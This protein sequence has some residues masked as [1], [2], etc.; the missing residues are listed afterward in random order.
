MENIIFS[1]DLCFGLNINIYSFYKFIYFTT[2]FFFLTEFKTTIIFSD[3]TYS[4][5]VL[6]TITIFKRGSG[7]YSA[8]DNLLCPVKPFTKYM[9]V[10]N[11]KIS[12][13]RWMTQNESIPCM[14]TGLALPL[15]LSTR[16]LLPAGHLLDSHGLKSVLRNF[17]GQF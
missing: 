1:L 3:K 6:T 9:Y 13:Q 12:A 8:S 7:I 5:M 4:L 16:H 10:N 11:L 14:H 2:L 15:L 17:K